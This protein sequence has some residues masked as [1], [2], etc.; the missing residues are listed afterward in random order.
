MSD[1]LYLG[2]AFGWQTDYTA[3]VAISQLQQQSKITIRCPKAQLM[4]AQSHLILVNGVKILGYIPVLNI[5]AGG[6]AIHFAS[7]GSSERPNN[8]EFWILRGVCMI[9]LG[10]LLAIV[11][12][13]KTIHDAIIAKKYRKEN[14]ELMAKFNTAH[15]HNVPGWPGHPVGCGLRALSISEITR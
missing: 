13:I 14:P 1:Q 7:S 5:L 6:L 12:A 3:K 2:E 10:P 15:G 11:D 9:F 4:Q 8:R